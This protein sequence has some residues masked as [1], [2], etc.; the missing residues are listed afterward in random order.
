MI[1]AALRADRLLGSIGPSD[2]DRAL[3][4]WEL[5]VL[6]ESQPVLVRIPY[7]WPS[8]MMRRKLV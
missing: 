7:L 4:V 6:A 2:I 1:V 3:L 5:G 8:E